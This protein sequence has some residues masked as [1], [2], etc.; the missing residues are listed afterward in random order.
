MEGDGFPS[1]HCVKSP[2]GWA[3]G[4]LGSEPI[5]WALVQSCSSACPCPWRGHFR[6]AAQGAGEQG[7]QPLPAPRSGRALLMSACSL[8]GAGE[9]V[10]VLLGPS[11]S[12]P[13]ALL[14]APF[15]CACWRCGWRF[16]SPVSR[17]PEGQQENVGSSPL[18]LFPSPEL[19]GSLPPSFSLL[20]AFCASVVLWGAFYDC[21]RDPGRA[22]LFSLYSNPIPRCI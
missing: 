13:L 4:R 15:V 1:L 17:I 6:A 16:C 3:R 8:A 7:S 22:G 5:L 20:D 12:S 11:I 2:C 18:G 21:N 9:K 14:G 10:S 19:P